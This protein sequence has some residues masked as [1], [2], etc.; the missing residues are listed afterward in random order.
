MNKK[1]LIAAITATL[2]GT[3]NA[4]AADK[5]EV[6][7]EGKTLSIAE[8]ALEAHLAHGDTLGA[9]ATV[10]T[11]QPAT[12]EPIAEEPAAEEPS[13][14]EPVT[15]TPVAEQPATEEPAPTT[16]EPAPVTE[17][18]IADDTTD[19]TTT[20]ETPPPV[21]DNV[22]ALPEP[23]P[24]EIL[25]DLLASAEELTV[26]TFSGSTVL[27]PEVQVE[28]MGT[29][30]AFAVILELIPQENG[31]A[32]SL[33]GVKP[34]EAREG[35]IAATY[36]LNDGILII[37]EIK[38]EVFPGQFVS[39][40]ATLVATN[41]EPLQLAIDPENTHPII[42]EA[43]AAEAPVAEEP[44]TEAPAAEEPTTEAPA[45]EEP[46]TEAPAAEEPATEVPATE[47]IT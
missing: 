13:A 7:H 10:P 5:V 3:M 19:D 38:V 39:F 21:D 32:F 41:F 44:A 9:C 31:M 22:V 42:D 20:E 33:L 17:E 15:E 24:E 2:A 12:E 1:L 14:E 45:A 16:E 25:A 4:Y 46:A 28:V 30:V 11:E 47:E 37:P 26:S 8:A 40:Y 36:S 18:P 34:V 6:C 27:M 35:V 23:T 43:P 29:T